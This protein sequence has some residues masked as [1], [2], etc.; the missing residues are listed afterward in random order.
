MFR[1]KDPL[2]QYRKISRIAEQKPIEPL[3]K[4]AYG[5]GGDIADWLLGYEST[6]FKQFIK[7][8]GNDTLKELKVGRTPINATIKL[9]FDLLAGGEFSKA[10]KQLGVDEFFH[11]YLV[12]NN[13]FVI[14]KN[15]T[16]N[17]KPYH[18][19]ADEQSHDIALP[20]APITIADFIKKADDGKHFWLEYDPIKNNCQMWVAKVLG[21]NGLFNDAVIKKFVLQDTEELLKHMPNYNPDLVRDIVDTGSI[22]NRIIQFATKGR[23]GFAIGNIDLGHR[24]VFEI[25]R[26]KVKARFHIR[27]HFH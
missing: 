7:Q 2:D 18:K 22:I 3:P 16:V 4:P 23:L 13:R 21:A 15:E 17:V 26:P 20:E 19:Q 11:L 27:R 14:E 24:D 25:Y 1:H 12:L 5:I 9:G 10:Q 6:R 8:H